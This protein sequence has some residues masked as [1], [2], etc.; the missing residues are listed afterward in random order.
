MSLPDEA[1]AEFDTL[2]ETALALETLQRSP[3][4]PIVLVL[5][6]FANTLGYSPQEIEL[7]LARLTDLRFIEGPGAYNDAWLFRRLTR[8]GRD[9][10]DEVRSE[11]RWE[12]IKRAYLQG[13]D[14]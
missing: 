10:V 11:K 1:D 9:F 7:V 6:E 4:E 12:E 8:R 5:A 3:P 14:P 2:R 13:D